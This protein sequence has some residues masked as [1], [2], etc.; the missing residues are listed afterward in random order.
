MHNDYRR[1]NV[2]TFTDLEMDIFE[3]DA[4]LELTD[5]ELEARKGEF[6]YTAEVLE[7]IVEDEDLPPGVSNEFYL[8]YHVYADKL[9]PTTLVIEDDSNTKVFRLHRPSDLSTL[10]N[11]IMTRNIDIDQA[12]QDDEDMDRFN[13]EQDDRDDDD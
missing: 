2:V 9:N 13:R 11:T 1:S 12:R 6:I 10:S 3:Q 8:D 5:S 4:G 7:D